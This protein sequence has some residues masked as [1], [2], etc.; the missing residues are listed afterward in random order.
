MTPYAEK[1]KLRNAEYVKNYKAW[2]DALPPDERE[3]LAEQD[4]LAPKV[5]IYATGKGK[6]IADFGMAGGVDAAVANDADG[7]MPAVVNDPGLPFASIEGEVTWK[8][9]RRLIGDIMGE[10]NA[11]LALEC[12]ALVSGLNFDG[13]SMTDIAR[14]HGLT[15]AAVSKRCVAI[16]RR[17]G[18]PPSRAMRQPA[19]RRQCA[20]AQ[21]QHRNQHEHIND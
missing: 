4:L 6:D 8:V 1:Q 2:V 16:T 15:R 5:E 11:R 3:R 12:F 7:A 18:L 20:R 17:L 13:G 14:R 21:L 10:T 9:V 19:C